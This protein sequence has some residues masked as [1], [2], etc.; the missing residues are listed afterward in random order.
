M[1]TT[2]VVVL[3]YDSA[4][5]AAF[6]EIRKEIEQ[7]A[8]DLIVDVEHVGSTSVEGMSAKP[9]IDLDVVIPDHT[10]FDAVADRLKAIGYFHEGDLGIKGREAF[11][12][13]GKP[14]LLTHHLYVCPRDSRELHRHVTFRNFLR[15]HPEAVKQYSTVKETAARL[16][17]DDIDRYMAYKAPCIQALYAQCGLTD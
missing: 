14:H 3:P 5:K 8:G 10:V 9:C 13:S 16:F 15:S 17:P 7:A 11:R 2:K 4:W 6:E 12:Y 1:R